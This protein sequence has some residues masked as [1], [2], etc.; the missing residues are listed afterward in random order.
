[1]W[2]CPVGKQKVEKSKVSR[3][4][5]IS[6][7]ALLCIIYINSITVQSLRCSS[8]RMEIDSER[9]KT[10]RSTFNGKKFIAIYE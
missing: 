4:I 9:D 6:S 3:I 1:M 8:S 10:Q 5:F 2:D 7:H